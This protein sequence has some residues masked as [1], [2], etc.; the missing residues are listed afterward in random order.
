MCEQLCGN[1][2]H[3]GVDIPPVKG[4]SFPV[5]L[6]SCWQREYDVRPYNKFRFSRL[7]FEER[8]N[9]SYRCLKDLH[10]IVKF[11]L[12]R[13]LLS[14]SIS[15][16]VVSNRDAKLLRNFVL[17]L[18]TVPKIELKLMRLPY[19]F[20]VMLRLKAYKMKLC[21]LSLMGKWTA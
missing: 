4:R 1:D 2:L 13:R 15:G 17:S 3:C 18:S 20:F 7:D 16:I 10:T 21:E 19:E 12:Q 8:M 6:L 5:L 11:M 14:V 9:R